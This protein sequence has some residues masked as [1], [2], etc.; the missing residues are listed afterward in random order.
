MIQPLIKQWRPTRLPDW[1]T[2]PLLNYYSVIWLMPLYTTRAKHEHLDVSKSNP[3]EINCPL[4]LCPLGPLTA[5]SAN[6]IVV[7]SSCFL[8]SHYINQRERVAAGRCNQ[9]YVQLN[10]KSTLIR[11]VQFVVCHVDQT[12][13]RQFYRAME[14]NYKHS[15]YTKNVVATFDIKVCFSVVVDRNGAVVSG[16]FDDLFLVM[17]SC[18]RN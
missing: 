13:L 11:S 5:L 12:R 3:F 10:H 9:L 1:M 18:Y 2:Q 14:Q 17:Y 16:I 8:W 7:F 6:L 4:F 15:T